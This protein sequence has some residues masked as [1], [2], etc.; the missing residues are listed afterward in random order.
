MTVILP[1]NPKRFVRRVLIVDDE[2]KWCR[3]MQTL[4]ADISKSCDFEVAT[5]IALSVDE[6]KQLISQRHFHLVSLDMWMPLASGAMGVEAAVELARHV[7]G[8]GAGTTKVVVYSGTFKPEALGFAE[9]QSDLPRVDRYRKSYSETDDAEGFVEPLTQLQWAKR[10]IE[11]LEPDSLNFFSRHRKSHSLDTVTGCWLRQA[12]KHLPC[13]LARHATDLDSAWRYGTDATRRVDVALRFIEAATRM[14]WA[15]TIT[16][17]R[18]DGLPLSA[19]MVPADE[20]LASCIAVLRDLITHHADR[21]RA[22]NWFWYLK[23]GID[24]L[25]EGRKLRN[26]D[27]HSLAPRSAG[28]AW[29]TMQEPM[30]GAMDLS[31][32]WAQNPLWTEIRPGPDGW[33]GECIAANQWPR[34][35]KAVPWPDVPQEARRGRGVWQ[36]AVRIDKDSAKIAWVRWHDWLDEDANGRSWWMPIYTQNRHRRPE[37]AFLDIDGGHVMTRSV[38]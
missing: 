1:S 38:R 31:A 15:Q 9:A 26:V 33:T 7:I 37:M 12:P 35:R 11:Y 5:E 24:A 8:P 14:A 22:W 36:S 10:V 4:L 13:L 28:S 27:R 6:A 18:E 19:P 2:P 21:L 17:L 23:R 32:Y 30:M 25:E 16:I 3:S 29:A 20:T 34:A